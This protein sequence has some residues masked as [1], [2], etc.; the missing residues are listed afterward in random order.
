MLHVW[1]TFT[2]IYLQK[3][4][5]VGWVKPAPLNIASNYHLTPKRCRNVTS[6]GPT[7]VDLSS[8]DGSSYFRLGK[9]RDFRRCLAFNNHFW[10]GTP[11]YPN[12]TLTAESRLN[13]SF[14]LHR[15]HQFLPL[16]IWCIETYGLQQG[17]WWSTMIHHWIL[18][19]WASVS[20]FQSYESWHIM[21]KLQ[22]GNSHPT[23]KVGC[24]D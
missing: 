18:V 12:L 3:S 22:C 13:G 14:K 19:M 9:T 2:N 7:V 24:P 5:N 16:S 15:C 1:N 17:E 6:N 10:G 11:W 4:P 8:S 20:H 23:M 21:A